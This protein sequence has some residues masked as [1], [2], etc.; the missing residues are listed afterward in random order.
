MEAAALEQQLRRCLYLASRSPDKRVAGAAWAAYVFLQRAAAG[1]A[2]PADCRAKV[3]PLAGLA[4]GR[5]GQRQTALCSKGSKPVPAHPS[6]AAEAGQWQTLPSL[7]TPLPCLACL[8]ACR[9]R[10]LPRQRPPTSLARRRAG[11]SAGSWRAC[12]AACPPC[13]PPCCPPSSRCVAQCVLMCVGWDGFG[14]DVAC[15]RELLLRARSQSVHACKRASACVPPQP[16]PTLHGSPAAPSPAG[17]GGGAQRAPAAGG[18]A[19]AGCRAQGEQP[20]APLWALA[21]RSSGQAAGGLG[22]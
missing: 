16:N 8:P 1:G 15:E 18:S 19:A 14:G 7:I 21:W 13:C 6:C 5:C 9:A 2:A 22:L 20:S 10:S 4:S 3:R 12:C 11:C 17:R